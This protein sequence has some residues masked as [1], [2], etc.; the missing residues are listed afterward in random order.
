MGQKGLIDHSLP[1]GNQDSARKILRNH[2]M[3]FFPSKSCLPIDYECGKSTF[4]TC[5]FTLLRKFVPVAVN[6]LP[7]KI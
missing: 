7:C 3:L 6:K 2:C 4:K 1:G 5:I